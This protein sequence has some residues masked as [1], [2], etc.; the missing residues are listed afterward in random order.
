MREWQEFKE[1]DV[2]EGQFNSK[3]EVIDHFVRQGKP[4]ASGAA[5]WERGWR[6][7]TKAKPT[8]MKN[9]QFKKPPVK[10]W[11]ELDEFAPNPTAQA[12][13]P[14]AQQ[15]K[16]KET[17]NAQRNISTL[18]AAGVNVPVGVSAAASNAVKT[19]N[20]PKANQA[21]GQ[22]IDPTGKNILGNF[23]AS[24]EDLVT[25]GNPSQVQ[26]IANAIKQATITPKK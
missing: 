13:N 19:V 2:A 16:A 6:G 5:A 7:P 14:V 1:Q 20:D 11:Q 22:G 12:N 25:K 10:N 15:Q 3:Q 17:Q 8:D 23:G 4:A 18:K 26:T 21:T 9:F 24:V